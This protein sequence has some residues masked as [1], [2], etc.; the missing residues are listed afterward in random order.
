MATASVALLMDSSNS[1]YNK[2]SSAY[3]ALFQARKH[4]HLPGISP[5]HLLLT[6]SSILVVNIWHMAQL[7]AIHFALARLKLKSPKLFRL[8]VSKK[9]NR[10]GRKPEK[11]IKRPQAVKAVI[12]I[13]AFP[14]APHLFTEDNSFFLLIGH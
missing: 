1:K 11:T 6:S 2:N 12:E 14:V 10:C 3:C 4:C 7:M 5:G 13:R 9:R 8:E